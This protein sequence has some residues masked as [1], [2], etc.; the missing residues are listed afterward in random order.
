MHVIWLHVLQLVCASEIVYSSLE[1]TINAPF[2]VYLPGRESCYPQYKPVTFVNVSVVNLPDEADIC[3]V[4]N[5]PQAQGDDA[6][7][8]SYV[9][10]SCNDDVISA[11][12]KQRGYLALIY[13]ISYFDDDLSAGKMAK[14]MFYGCGAKIPL[15]LGKDNSV[16]NDYSNAS[17]R[18]NLYASDNPALELKN[19]IA[20][21]IG[22]TV[23]GFILC[24]KLYLIS[25]LVV[26]LRR[27]KFGVG[28]VIMI[29]EAMQSLIGLCMLADFAGFF[30]LWRYDVYVLLLNSAALMSNLSTGIVGISYYHALALADVVNQS[31]VVETSLKVLLV[32]FTGVSIFVTLGTADFIIVTLPTSLINVLFVLFFNCVFFTFFIRSKSK[33]FQI[34]SAVGEKNV[35]DSDLKYKALLLKYSGYLGIWVTVWLMFASA[36]LVILGSF[37]VFSW[38]LQLSCT[39]YAL[40]GI[41]QLLSLG[42]ALELSATQRIR[43]YLEGTGTGT[44]S[45]KITTSQ[46]SKNQQ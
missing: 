4:E 23:T 18:V 28:G 25:L 7:L 9:N 26:V 43:G 40:N 3:Y 1:G 31:V 6:V 27:H 39:G 12:T 45:R 16:L 32:V 34:F 24:A 22:S 29:L 19:N 46:S 36:D 2:T 14:S 17:I 5:I 10:P 33:V 15:Y 38:S 21:I 20:G 41:T 44:A 42:I 37:D 13:L 8:V 35:A 30:G 11:N